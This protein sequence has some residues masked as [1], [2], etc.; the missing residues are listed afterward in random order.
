VLEIVGVK[1]HVTLWE[2]R[3][4]GRFPNPVVLGPNSGHRSKI[5]YIDTEVYAAIHNLPRRLPRN[6]EEE[7]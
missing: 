4:Q 6:P 1:S 3:R 7:R 2:W 5:G